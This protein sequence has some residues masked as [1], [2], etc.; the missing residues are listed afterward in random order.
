M[1]SNKYDWIMYGDDD[2]LIRDMSTP[3][4][5]LL[6]EIQLFGRYQS[7]SAILPTDFI[8]HDQLCFSSFAILLKNS[9]FGREILERWREFGM[10]LC[11]KGN[12]KS[13]DITQYSW[14]D[15]DQPGLKQG[16]WQKAQMALP[17]PI[18]FESVATSRATVDQI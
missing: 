7:V 18:T 10:G 15:S 3:L 1:D 5:S 4:E 9:P 13:N 14:V 8:E 12:Y 16:I 17:C 6:Q 2:L 11:A